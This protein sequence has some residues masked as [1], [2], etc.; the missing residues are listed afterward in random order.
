MTTPMDVLRDAILRKKSVSF[1]YHNPKKSPKPITKIVGN[2][3]ALYATNTGN[4][5]LDLYQTSGEATPT[6]KDYTLAYILDLKIL[7]SE[8]SFTEAPDY[9]SY[10]RKYERKFIKL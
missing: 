6:W 4:I 7:E 9:K 8:P 5:N 3:H 10:A 1:S 2:P